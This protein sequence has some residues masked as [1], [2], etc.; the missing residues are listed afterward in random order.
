MAIICGSMAT[1]VHCQVGFSQHLFCY[2]TH[3]GVPRASCEAI[4]GSRLVVL[5]FLYQAEE[6]AALA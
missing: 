5:S 3:P 2:T 1:L 6:K 4:A